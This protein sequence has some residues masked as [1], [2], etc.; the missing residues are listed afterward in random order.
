MSE[1]KWGDFKIFKQYSEKKSD[2]FEVL[3]DF[4]KCH[5]KMTSPKRDV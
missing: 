4:L 1:I 3:L 2:N 5:Y